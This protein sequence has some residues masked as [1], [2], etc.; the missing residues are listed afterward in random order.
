VLLRGTAIVSLLTLLSRFLGF[1]RDLLVAK[2]LGASLF[3]DAFF[4]AFRIPNLLRSFVAEG[5]LTSAFVPVF[6]STLARSKE[7]AVGSFRRVLGFLLGLTIPLSVAGIWYA[8][9]V[10]DFLAPGFSEQSEKFALCI[11]LTQVMMPYIACV[12][13]IAMINS[14]LNSLHIFGAS[15]WAQVIM[16]LVLIGGATAAMVLDQESATYVLSYSVLIGGVAQVLA[17]VPACMRA[18]LSLAP[19]FAVFGRDVF[20]VIRLMIPAALGAS[21][22]QITIFIATL[23][24]SLLPEGRVSWLFY[25]DRVAQFPIGIFSVALAS[26]LLPALSTANAKADT[27]EFQRK[28]TDSLRYTSFVIIPMAAGIW[29]LALPIT[30]LLFER[31]AF[32]HESSLMTS[33]ALQA[34][35]LGLWA[36]SCHSMIVRA[37]IA[38]KDTV[39][40][41][42]I[43]L[44]SLLVTVIVSLLLMGE[45]TNPSGSIPAWL[46]G[47]QAA[48]YEKVGWHAA[49]GHRGLAAASSAA[50]FASLG[51]VLCFFSWRIGSFPWRSFGL[52]TVRASFASLL[53]LFALA[54]LTS[55]GVSAAAAVVIGVPVGAIVYALASLVLRS[56]EARESLV[57]LRRIA[58][59]RVGR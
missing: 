12:S 45:I 35:A 28:L 38:R 13:V 11:K 52:A 31:G 15:A 6:S 33:Y 46:A 42:L 1:L 59:R 56:P 40:P 10:V 43:G 23:L 32:S 48:L 34:L 26:V 55:F 20:E 7:E 44:C 22:Y 37:F 47:V 39:T 18:G 54:Q 41:T 49:I 50:A 30:E 3:A 36:T 58:S 29:S 19:S 4:V 53:M 14:A 25:A 24:A 51:L 2:L 9:E 8:P 5:A 17:Q 21:V 27:G 16:N 57:V